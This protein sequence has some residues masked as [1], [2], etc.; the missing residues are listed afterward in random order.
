MFDCYVL[1][2]RLGCDEM[3][4]KLHPRVESTNFAKESLQTRTK[5]MT[6]TT[7]RTICRGPL[8]YH[9]PPLDSFLLKS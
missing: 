2:S 6:N 3:R 7:V 8:A 9:L 5:R 4:K 1:D